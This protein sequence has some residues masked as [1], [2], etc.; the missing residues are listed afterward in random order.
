MGTILSSVKFE[1]E[2]PSGWVLFDFF[3]LA[4]FGWGE[5]YERLFNPAYDYY[6]RLC[7]LKD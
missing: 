7:Q 4:Y 2:M 6:K 5:D 3:F 1:K